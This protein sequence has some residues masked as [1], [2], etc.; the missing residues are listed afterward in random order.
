MKKNHP[1]IINHQFFNRHFNQQ[2]AIAYISFGSNVGDRKKHIEDAVEI[3]KTDSSIEIKSVS[4]LYETEPVGYEEQ[5]W[6]INGVLEIETELSPH[7]LL[8]FVK[9]VESKVGRRK[10]IRWGPRE[11]DLDIL[12]YEQECI[13]TPDLVIPHP[14]MQE[15]EF[16][17]IPLVEIAPDVVHPVF[18]KS[19]ELLLKDLPQK[20]VVKRIGYDIELGD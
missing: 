5:D 20:K 18:R 3:L 9:T 11:I 10:S 7:E 8:R 4:S 16:V 15:R 19:V 2:S 12:L 1:S 13:N 17:L 14:R 6:F